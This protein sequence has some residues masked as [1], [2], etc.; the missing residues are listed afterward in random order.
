MANLHVRNI[1]GELYERLRKHARKG[2]RTISATVLA[3]VER[4]LAWSEWESRLAQHPTTDLGVDVA[5][6]LAEERAHRD[7]ETE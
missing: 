2:N 6:L 4:E 1:P 5:T 7:S 3:A